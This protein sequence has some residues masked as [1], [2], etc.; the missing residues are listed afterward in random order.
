MPYN[1]GTIISSNSGYDSTYV[2]YTVKDNDTLQSI[3]TEFGTSVAI[4]IQLNNLSIDTVSGSTL[5]VGQTLITPAKTIEVSVESPQLANTTNVASQQSNNTKPKITVSHPYAKVE[6]ATETGMISLN[7]N[8]A[9]TSD[10]FDGDVLSLSTN[11]DI[12]QDCPTFTLRVVYRRD[13]YSKINSNDLIIISLCRPPESKSRIMVGLVDDIRKATDFSTGKPIRSFDIT[14]RGFNKAL[15]NFAVGVISEVSDMAVSS[16]LGF[17]GNMTDIFTGK[18]PAAIL[19]GVL[20]HYLREGCNYQFANGKSY[21]DYY[22][23]YL[24]D[25]VNNNEIL[26]NSMSFLDYQGSLWELLKE[27]KNAPFNELFWEIY[28]DKPTLVLRPT[29]FNEL[30]WSKLEITEIDDINI[31]SENIGRSD[32]ETYTVYSVKATSF[33][34]EVDLSGNF[35][36]WYKP[37][38][39]KYGLSRLQVN[40]KFIDTSGV[41]SNAVLIAKQQDIF[42]WNIKN[43]FMENGTITVMGSNKYKVGS[44]ATIKSTGV[45]YYIESVSH[46]FTYLTGWQTTISI[47]RGLQPNN[48]FTSPWGDYVQMTPADASEIYGYDVQSTYMGSGTLYPSI[49]SEVIVTGVGNQD[50]VNVAQAELG[51]NETAGTHLKYITAYN[52]SWGSG[53]PWCACFVSWCARQSRIPENVIPQFSYCPTGVSWFKERNRFQPSEYQGGQEYTPK[54]GDIIFFSDSYN[55]TL[56]SHVGIVSSCDGSKVYTVEGNTSDKVG[57]NSYVMSSPYIVGYGLPNYG[58]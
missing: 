45:E 10:N 12:G 46:S 4:L 58:Q 40:T 15:L 24:T 41:D 54:P 23:Q 49:G 53:T 27:V 35:P 34:G 30:D 56:S 33:I 28:N 14:G 57:R 2:E 52:S 25:N 38:Y 20:G 31:V 32:L 42:N 19:N 22:Q 44:R 37:Y 7:Q 5:Q 36:L 48:R 9:I 18:S 1:P 47:T 16:G 11:R 43:N 29:P 26:E 6:V 51:N 55:I 3:A 17:M 8:L 13:W 50:I 39:L 21:L